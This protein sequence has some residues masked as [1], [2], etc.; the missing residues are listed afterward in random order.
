[1]GDRARPGHRPHFRSLSL[2]RES[3]RRG[4]A[5]PDDRT[6]TKAVLGARPARTI[7]TR[8]EE[9]FRREAATARTRPA[10]G[11]NGHC[12]SLTNDQ[13]ASSFAAPAM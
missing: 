1:M 8:E 11:T 9:A 12:H 5:L 13:V 10:R 3:T 2:P 4:V 6:A 7:A